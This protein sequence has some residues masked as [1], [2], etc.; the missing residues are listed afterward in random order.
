MIVMDARICTD[1]AYG[2]RLGR[3]AAYT[4]ATRDLTVAEWAH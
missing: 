4:E 3:S 2:W 1:F